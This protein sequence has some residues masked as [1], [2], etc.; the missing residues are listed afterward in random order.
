LKR[1]GERARRQVLR[2]QADR[3]G[4]VQRKR[5]GERARRQVLR[6]QADR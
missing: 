6:L 1:W 4:A 5:W 3:Q 2:R